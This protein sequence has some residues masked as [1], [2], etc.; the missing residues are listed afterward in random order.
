MSIADIR[1]DYQLESLDETKVAT[2]PFLQFSR[3]WDDAVKS[4]IDEV[5]AFTLATADKSGMPAARILLLKGFDPRGFV[6]FSNYNSNK[7]KELEDNPRASMVFFWKELE[8]QVRIS[9]SVEKVDAAES[10]A[11]FHSR[12]AGSRLG[13]WA[14][15]QS[16]VISSRLVLQENVE[17]LQKEFEGKEIPRPPH[18]GGYLLRPKSVEFWQ[19]RPSRLH[20]RIL[21]RSDEKGS[22]KLERLSP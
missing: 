8:R 4:E 22:W 12:P 6:F 11:Y 14:S 1:K 20:D 13:A 2:D 18:W 15:A 19:G 7:G 9:G 10:D 3:W 5:N 17:R 21:Y 16:S